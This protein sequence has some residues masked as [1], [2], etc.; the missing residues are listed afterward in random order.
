ML[1]PKSV[2]AKCVACRD[3]DNSK[4]SCFPDRCHI[5]MAGTGIHN[6]QFDGSACQKARLQ[7]HRDIW[8]RFGG[9]NEEVPAE[10]Q[11]Q[12]LKTLQVG[13][14]GHGLAKSALQ[15]F[16]LVKRHFKRE[17][18]TGWNRSPGRLRAGTQAARHPPTLPDES[19]AQSK[20]PAQPPAPTPE[21]SPAKPTRCAEPHPTAPPIADV[22]PLRPQSRR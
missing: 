14:P 17:L 5:L 7:Q 16:L 2:I 15:Q 9:G 22:S 13:L 19:T 6:L 8:I 18:T 4:F 10:S 11:Q 20:K 3:G 12:S 21:S 1:S